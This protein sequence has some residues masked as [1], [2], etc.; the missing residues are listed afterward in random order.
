MEKIIETLK[1]TPHVRGAITRIGVEKSMLT[2]LCVAHGIARSYFY[3]KKALPAKSIKELSRA[4]DEEHFV[5][6]ELDAAFERNRLIAA[7]RVFRGAKCLDATKYPKNPLDF[8]PA[9]DSSAPS[10][11]DY[12]T[13]LERYIAFEPSG[14]SC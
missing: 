7:T 2:A 1:L 10:T 4:L 5:R 13:A 12:R 14:E 8:L 6:H 3:G 9:S 11:E